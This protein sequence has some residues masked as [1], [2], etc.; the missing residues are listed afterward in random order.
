DV[1]VAELA[2]VM[3]DLRDKS[4]IPT[5]TAGIARALKM[6]E[7]ADRPWVV[8]LRGRDADWMSVSAGWF[9]GGRAIMLLQLNNDREYDDASLSVVLRAYLIETLIRKQVPELVFW[10]GTAPPLSRYAVPLPVV[11]V[12]IDARTLGWRLLRFAAEKVEPLLPER[13]G[14]NIRW[15]TNSLDSAPS[16]RARAVD[17][18]S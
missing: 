11:A 1:P 4:R 13:I 16:H 18:E 7:S 14:V 6:I 9:S 12:H 8:G 17:A 10:C 15:I 5:D 3:T 2:R